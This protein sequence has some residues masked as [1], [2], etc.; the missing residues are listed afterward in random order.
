M[1]KDKVKGFIDLVG[2]YTCV[3]KVQASD[4]T[5]GTLAVAAIDIHGTVGY[6]TAAGG[7]LSVVLQPAEPRGLIVWVLDTDASADHVGNIDVVGLDQNGVPVSESIVMPATTGHAH[8]VYAYSA[9]TSIYIADVISG[10]YGENDHVAVGYDNRIGL[11][12]APGCTYVSKLI[13]TFDGAPTTDTL[14][15]TYGTID[16]TGTMDGAKEV[17][18]AFTYK[19]EI[20]V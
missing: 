14:N 7:A 3:P 12:A 15:T 20:P 18:V 19:I 5:T 1:S 4:T 2:S 8:S 16:M 11:P 13:S 9:L 10:T 17:M 6:N